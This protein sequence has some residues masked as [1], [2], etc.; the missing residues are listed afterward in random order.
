MTEKKDRFS[1][2]AI[3]EMESQLSKEAVKRVRQ[4]AIKEVKR[5]REMEKKK[6]ES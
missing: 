6:K 3:A 1:I 2:D 4:N 5:I